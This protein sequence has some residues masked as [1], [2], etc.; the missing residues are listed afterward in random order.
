MSPFVIFAKRRSK[1]LWSRS[2]L[3]KDD[4][5]AMYRKMHYLEP[6]EHPDSSEPLIMVEIA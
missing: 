1:L 6:I 5:R 3:G 2:S 4:G